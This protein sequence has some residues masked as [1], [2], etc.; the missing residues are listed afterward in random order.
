MAWAVGLDVEEEAGHE[1]V[2][3]RLVL[4]FCEGCC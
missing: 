1:Y 3:G 4:S 2:L